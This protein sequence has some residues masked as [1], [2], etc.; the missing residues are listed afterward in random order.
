[1]N[2]KIKQALNKKELLDLNEVFAKYSQKRREKIFKRAK[3]LQA[4][5]AI[6]KLRKE[7]KFSQGDLARK[8]NVEREYIARIESGKQNVTLET[9]YRIAEATK[10]DF[11]FQ[12]KSSFI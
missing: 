12:F 10:R 8:M 4:A 11:V 1:M 5:I 9:L 3:Y 2:K 6:R 7:L